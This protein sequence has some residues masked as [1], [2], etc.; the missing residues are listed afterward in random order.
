MAAPTITKN[1]IMMAM[2]DESFAR[3]VADDVKNR[4]SKPQKQ[5]LELPENN[6]RWQRALNVLISNLEEQLHQISLDLKADTQ[7]Y[8][9]LGSVGDALLAGATSHYNLKKEKIERFKFYVSNKLSDVVA[10]S[11]NS[12]SKNEIDESILSKAIITHMNM[13]NQ[14]NIAHTPIDEALYASLKGIWR[15]EDIDPDDLMEFSDDAP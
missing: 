5:Y 14:Y 1:R 4:V 7:R 9:D 10:S 15:F 8:S 13:N 12:V 6:K 3:L 2:N 11:E